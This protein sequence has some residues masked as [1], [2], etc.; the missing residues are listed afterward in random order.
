MAALKPVVVH[1]VTV[2]RATLHNEEEIE[3]KDVRIGDHVLVQRAG[4]VIPEVVRPVLEKRNGSERKFEFPKQCPC[5]GSDVRRA[6]GEVAIRCFNEEC[7]AQLL[8][9]LEHFVSKRA[10][11]IVGLGPKILED[12]FG[13]GLVRRFSDLYSLK[14][15]QI[16]GLEGFREKSVAKL[17]D[18]IA[19]SRLKDLSTF[20]MALGIRHVGEQTAK[21]LAKKFQTLDRF[22]EATEGELAETEDVGPTISKSI[23]VHLAKPAFQEEVSRLLQLGLN[24]KSLSAETMGNA[25]SGLTFVV[26]GTLPVNDRKDIEKMIEAEGGKVSSSV[27]KK[28]SY[29]IVGE[30]A[31]SKLS[32]ARDLGVPILSEEQFLALLN[33]K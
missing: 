20:I 3:R 23:L 33:N 24:P 8:G 4:D 11:D 17:L 16:L 31:G 26:T 14:A 13:R 10:M 22:M 32:K 7:P 25:F 12:F 2:A 6:E 1:G 18:S 9:A 28:T 15:E 5:C 27:S 30:D 29:I 19:A 21:A